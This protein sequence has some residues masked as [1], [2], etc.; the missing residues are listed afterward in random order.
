M[1]TK[2]KNRFLSF[3]FSWI[4]GAGEMYMGFFKTGLSLMSLFALI[5]AVAVLINQGVL[6]LLA[7]VEWA[8]SFFHANHLASLADEEFAGVEDEYLFGLGE[9]TEIR[10]LTGKYQKVAAGILIFVGVCFLWDTVANLLYYILPANFQFIARIMWNIGDYV[11]SLMIAFVIIAFGVRLLR[12]K[13]VEMG[14]Q[15]P[16]GN[17]EE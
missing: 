7:V 6:A 14:Q 3:C 9:N 10:R 17:G 4:P 11:P 5:I 12:G 16:K 2:K 8:Y 15:A 1:K 13:S